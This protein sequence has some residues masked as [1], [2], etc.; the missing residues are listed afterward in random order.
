MM[1]SRDLRNIFLLSALLALGA[2]CASGAKKTAAPGGES[3][4]MGESA[5]PA[6]TDSSEPKLDE[7]IGEKSTGK[8]VVQEQA[9]PSDS[10][11]QNLGKALRAGKGEAIRDEAAKLLGHNSSD[12]VALN[13]LGLYYYRRKQYEAARILFVRGLERLPKSSPLLNNLGLIDLAE[14]DKPAAI[15]DFKKA[16]LADDKNTQAM[17]N[18]GTIYVQGGD[19]ARATPLLEQ[20]YKKNSSN[21][22]IANGYAITQR[23]A[24]N[25]DRA[26][27]IFEDLLK[28]NPKD[29]NILLN[30]AILLIDYMNKPKDGL[31]LVNKI[32][33]LENDKKEIISRANTLEKKAK[34]GIK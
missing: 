20:A 28:Q 23:A 26:Q 24:K 9:P 25:F 12:A 21:A 13:T 34:S 19:Y 27:S 2:G 16:L 22:M 5:T 30:D 17:G 14:G 3:A 18:L 31:V 15:A 6:E 32:K 8:P 11:Y 29:V 4:A 33:F 7:D 1:T 10:R